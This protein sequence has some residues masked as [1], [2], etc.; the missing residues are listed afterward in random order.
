[1]PRLEVWTESMTEQCLICKLTPRTVRTADTKE[2][3]LVS[4]SGLI[5][6]L[7][8]TILEMQKKIV[9]P[10][11]LGHDQ[12]WISYFFRILDILTKYI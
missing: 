5:R 11:C 10:E 2:E 12:L 6:G 7:L 9:Y 3:L 8:M 4:E 1:M